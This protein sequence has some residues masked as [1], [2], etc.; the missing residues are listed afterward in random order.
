MSSGVSKYWIRSEAQ[1][2]RTRIIL[3]Q[4][5]IERGNRPRS[6]NALE[7]S[8][9]WLIQHELLNMTHNV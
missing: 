6:I 3:L 4:P 1:Q 9:K 8:L 7:D 2:A 5:V